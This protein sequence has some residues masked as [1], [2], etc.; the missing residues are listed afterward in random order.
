MKNFVEI[1][2]YTVGLIGMASSA[3]F[4]YGSFCY[5]QGLSVYAVLLGSVAVIWVSC[6][7]FHFGFDWV[8]SMIPAIKLQVREVG[9]LVSSQYSLQ[10]KK[11]GWISVSVN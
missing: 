4:L 8:I 2:I 5:H 10:I 3:A 9:E 7:A 11:V 1:L 6:I